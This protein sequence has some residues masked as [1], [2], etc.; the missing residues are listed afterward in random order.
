[1]IKQ[2]KTKRCILVCQAILLLTVCLTTN[3]YSGQAGEL[4]P[5]AG[6]GYTIVKKA[7]GW[8]AAQ[9][10]LDGVSVRIAGAWSESSLSNSFKVEN[11]SDTPFILD[12]AKIKIEIQGNTAKTRLISIY[13][14]SNS[15]PKEEKG[16]TFDEGKHL[17]K[18][19]GNNNDG[20]PE[21]SGSMKLNCPPKQKCYYSIVVV[22]P[23]TKLNK[24]KTIKITVPAVTSGGK[25]TEVFFNCRRDG[26]FDSL[27]ALMKQENWR[28]E[29][30]V[31]KNLIL[32]G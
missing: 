26:I 16:E 8:E 9:V 18:Y 2:Q 27:T 19:Y 17:Y 28:N 22:F 25:D 15:I 13:D 21:S 1:M 11:N 20:K 29:R 10:A 23:E 6:E 31:G 5:Q 14:N 32:F 3:C 7:D 24:N 4:H 12:F 30:L